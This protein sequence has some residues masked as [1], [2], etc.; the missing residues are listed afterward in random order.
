MPE[1]IY[2]NFDKLLPREAWEERLNQ[3]GMVI[4]FTGLSGSGK[5][6]LAIH[7]ERA[8]HERGYLAKV[9]DGD[10]IRS[11]LNNNLGFTQE[12]RMENIRRI[13]EVSKLF[14]Q[15]GI[16]TITAFISPTNAMRDMAR[17]IIGAGNLFQ[18]YVDTPLEEC[19][20]RDVKGL[21]KKARS[22]A[23]QNFTG[24]SA[25]FEAPTAPDMTIDTSNRTVEES[26]GQLLEAILPRIKRS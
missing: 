22:G 9:L 17:E 23:I 15:S 24:L 2:T 16:I 1:N 7:L 12:D 6:T 25:G 14:V 4:W 3:R 13:A 26:V 8:L 10:N 21:Y 18:V 5:S 11:G 20:R 19:E